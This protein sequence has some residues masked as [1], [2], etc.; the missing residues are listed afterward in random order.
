MASSSS[1]L[2]FIELKSSMAS[3][4]SSSLGFIEFNSSMSSSSSSSWRHSF[5]SPPK[6]SFSA[7]LCFNR[8][9]KHAIKAKIKAMRL[10]EEEKKSSSANIEE[11]EKIIGYKFKDKILLQQAFTHPSFHG[12]ESYERLAYL[13]DAFLKLVFA[14][15]QVVMYPDLRK[16]S[17]TALLDANVTLEKLARGAVK[18][19]L[20]K[21]IRHE[22]PTLSEQ[23]EVFMRDLEKY[24]LHSYGL[25]DAPKTLADIVKSTIGVIGLD[26]CY[27]IDTTWEVVKIL[28]DPMI[29]PETLQKDPVR[30][31]KELCHK[32]KLKIQFRDKWLKEGVCEVFVDNELIGRGEYKA[33]K[34]IALNRAAEDAWINQKVGLL[35]VYGP[36]S[37]TL[38]A[39]L[40]D[41]LSSL[42]SSSSE[43]I[44]V[45]FGDFNAVRFREER[46]GT[47]FNI[48]E[49]LDFNQFIISTGLHEPQLCGRRFTRFSKDGLKMS[50]LDR[51]LVTTNFFSIWKNPTISVLHR[52]I[53]DHC[54]ILLKVEELISGPKPFRIFNSWLND[55]SFQRAVTL[56]WNSSAFEGTADFILKEK[57]KALK[58]ELKSW[59]FLEAKKKNQRKVHIEK[60]LLDWDMKAEQSVM[61]EDDRIKRDELLFESFQLD[62][63]ERSDLIQKA[64]IRWAVEGDE[65]SSFFHSLVNHRRRR[66]SIKGLVCDGIWSED[67]STIQT[68]IFNHFAERFHE[69]TPVRP[70][71]ICSSFS[72]LSTDEATGLEKP[73]S[74]DEIKD[75]VWSCD[76]SKSPGPD[77]LNFSFIKKFWSIIGNSFIQAIRHF[78]PSGRIG[79]G[80][81]ASFIALVPKKVD[82]IEIIDFRPISLIGCYYKCIAKLLANRLVKVMGRV[83]SGNQ[84]AFIPGRQILDGCLVANEI[85]HF[86]KKKKKKLFL[87][88]V[89]FEK[90][91]DCVN[92]N[93][94]FST[95]SQMGFGQKWIMWI[96]GCLQSA[97]TSVLIN[98]SPTK[99]FQ[100]KKGLRQG[101]PL[102]PF[103]FLIAGEVLQQM[104]IE[105]CNQGLFK[106]IRLASS[107]RNISLL[108]FADDALI[109]GKWTPANLV[110]LTQILNVFYDVSGLKINLA[111][112]SLLGIGVSTEE[113]NEMASRIGCRATSFP[114]NYLG[115][116]VGGNMNKISS[117]RQVVEKFNKKLAS[118]KANS[119][120]MGGRLTLINSVLTA[121][122]LYTFSLFKV[123]QGVLKVLESCRRRFFWGHNVGDKKICWISWNQILQP[124]SNGGLG[125][126]SLRVKNDALLSKWI[127][128]FYTE[129]GAVWKDVISEFYGADGGFQSNSI[130]TAKSTWASIV[131]N[132]SS[133]ILSGQNFLSSFKKSIAKDSDSLFWKDE[134]VGGGVKLKDVFPRLYALESDKNA[135]FKDR[136]K[137]TNDSW[138]GSWNWRTNLRGRS[139]GA[140]ID[141]E[142]RLTNMQIRVTGSDKWSWSWDEKGEFFVKHMVKLLNGNQR[143][144]DT[145]V[146]SRFWNNLLPIKLNLFLWRFL[147]DALPTR[148]NLSKR[149]I[150]IP[151][152]V[153][154]FC[155]SDVE[156]LD[157]CFFTCYRSSNIWKKIWAWWGFK[158]PRLTSSGS[159]KSLIQQMGK[160]RRCG[161]VF[162]AVCVV[163]LW[164]IWKWRNSIYAAK[165]EDL[166]KKKSEDIFP[167]IQ[168]LSKLWISNRNHRLHVNWGSW[169][170]NLPLG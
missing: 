138:S 6:N 68:A 148:L 45:V 93:F 152:L 117:W 153:C 126:T 12:S 156:S 19:N 134:T 107:G 79:K 4:S 121:M 131:N 26:N 139:V 102:S 38:K 105:A 48:R 169:C 118:W 164:Q 154:F 33:K 54:P 96:K 132:S 65:N 157:H 59:A 82:P 159:F 62:H 63:Q 163:T 158:S 124:K 37:P 92:W 101:D 55:E 13:G 120:S 87:F 91:F 141:L 24:P 85:V 77:G 30:R 50:K 145:V 44:W 144:R 8:L 89:D 36:H 123:P 108:Q 114:L 14:T 3:S 146:F 25:I 34:E 60:A 76:G 11:L 61:S 110:V 167:F 71:F 22:N 150:S 69:S 100:M 116:N 21:Y 106:G 125:I 113:V 136:W 42:I 90:A 72:R 10:P 40:W 81:N 160:G 15:K 137:F 98:G 109:F 86:A 170:N 140:L 127:W 17:H 111:K 47:S 168:N 162:L 73:F 46:K 64:R 151:S 29:T 129:A 43:V 84:T 80:C 31:L 5:L 74:D 78:E 9:Q 67:T 32:K 83:I 75:A 119:M 20:H 1:S 133:L 104:V 51:M 41:D 16:R 130:A 27:A 161:N 122:P 18:L 23:I 166:S 58:I 147:H 52:S 128:R 99:E 142:S 103:L 115:L 143:S 112:C 165:G 56:S 2:G 155:D 28:L 7:A 39:S 135:R 149:G 57:I 97:T 66:N 70:S 94:L 53:S 35:N 88:K 95:M 49:A